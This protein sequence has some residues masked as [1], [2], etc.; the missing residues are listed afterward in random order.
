MYHTEPRFT[1]DLDVFISGQKDDIERFSQAMGAFGFPLSEKNKQ[2]LLLPKQMIV[3]GNPPSR[4]DFL[5]DMGGLDFE[6][7]W[8]KRVTVDL[9]GTPT[10]YIDLDSLILAKKAAGRPQDKLDLKKL[11]RAKKKS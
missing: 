3:I 4:I 5:N 1:K 10:A 9:D 8:K 11:E 6:S 2:D 7:T